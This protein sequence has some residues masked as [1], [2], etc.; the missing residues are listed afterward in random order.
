M[1][2]IKKFK[3][4]D[5]DKLIDALKTEYN[6][7]GTIGYNMLIAQYTIA[8]G[9]L[10]LG[11]LV[12]TTNLNKYSELQVFFPFF[13]IVIYCC[14]FYNYCEVISMGGYRQ[15]IGDILNKEF[16]VDIF[17][18]EKFTR[19]NFHQNNKLTIIQST[20][21]ILFLLFAEINSILESPNVTSK[22]YSL[23]FINKEIIGHLTFGMVL[24]TIIYLIIGILFFLEIRNSYSLF[25]KSYNTAISYKLELVEKM[26]ED[27]LK[28]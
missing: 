28:K 17:N 25:N 3:N 5:R 18:W 7:L 23:R 22:I 20:T 4:A 8:G 13:L 1:E 27:N 21:C 14:I 16:K 6:S 19:N 2:T 15:A 26:S 9:L 10:I 11:T 12:Y 24:L